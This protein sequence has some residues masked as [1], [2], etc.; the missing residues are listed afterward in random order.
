MLNISISM[1]G[2]NKN[3]TIHEVLTNLNQCD[4]HKPYGGVSMI[5]TGDLKQ[6]GNFDWTV[7]WLNYVLEPV[8]DAFIFKSSSIHGRSR[9]AESLWSKFEN[10]HLTKKVRSA[11]DAEFSRLCDRIGFNTITNKDIEFLKGRDIE[12][13]Q[14]ND[15][16]N[17]K[18]GK[19]I[20]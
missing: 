19:V 18:Q 2:S 12:C 20:S 8:K 17:F 13:I 11:D 10:F 3:Q 15:P 1:V 7:F 16:E 4:S 9:A 14:E 6:L 5:F